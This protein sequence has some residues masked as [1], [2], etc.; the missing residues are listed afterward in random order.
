MHLAQFL[1]HFCYEYLFEMYGFFFPLFTVA[2]ALIL[3]LSC[4][5]L[6]FF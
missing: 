5:S 2:F 3:F 6:L 1:V 4:F